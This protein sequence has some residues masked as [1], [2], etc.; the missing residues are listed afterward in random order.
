[1]LGKSKVAVVNGCDQETATAQIGSQTA[2]RDRPRLL[3]DFA[4]SNLTGEYRL[5]LNDC[6]PRDQELRTRRRKHFIEEVA[7]G[8]P[9]VHFC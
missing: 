1:M 2:A 3:V 6:Q 9:A 4:G 8:L 5:Q 7:T